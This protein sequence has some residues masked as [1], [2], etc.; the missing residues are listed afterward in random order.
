MLHLLPEP[1]AVLGDDFQAI[2][3]SANYEWAS[4]HTWGTDV[5]T[6]LI[7]IAV[8]IGDVNHFNR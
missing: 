7:R 2:A 5:L 3:I 1:S 6:F 8:F 4:E